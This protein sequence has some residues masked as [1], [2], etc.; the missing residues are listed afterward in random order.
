MAFFFVML[1]GA[2]GSGL[3]YGVWLLLADESNRFP[4]ATFM[5]NLTG[6][7][8]IG[9][10][11]ALFARGTLDENGW[12]KL[13]LVTGMLGGFTTFSAFSVDTLRL[14]QAGQYGMASLYV[15]LSV[16]VCVGGCALGW[17][18]LR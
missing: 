4:W 15:L 3:R 17:W 8:G 16:V 13:L 2:L 9:L 1:G 18:V 7:V 6:S 5:V 12:V 11:A 10:L 14:L